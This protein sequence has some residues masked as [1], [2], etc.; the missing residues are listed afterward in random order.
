MQVVNWS[1]K[2]CKTNNNAKM[3]RERKNNSI[4]FAKCVLKQWLQLD[5][6]YWQFTN[7]DMALKLY[8]RCLLERVGKGKGG[9]EGQNIVLERCRRERER[10]RER[11]IQR[12]RDNYAIS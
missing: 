2:Q 9:C 7:K 4:Q 6:R 12:E 11:E 8:H 10:E 5:K 3:T 1:L